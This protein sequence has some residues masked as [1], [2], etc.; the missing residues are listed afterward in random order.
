MIRSA[1]SLKSCT[2]GATDG[3]VGD[4]KDVYFD[5]ERWVIRYLVVDTGE[6]LPNPIC[7]RRCHLTH[8][9][10][11][12]DRSLTWIPICAAPMT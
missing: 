10:R 6:W 8:R 2:I 5:D 7:S 12:S 9:S 4:V 11:S 3:E 1:D